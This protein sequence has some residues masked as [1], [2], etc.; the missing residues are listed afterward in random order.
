[1][2]GDEYIEIKLSN[3]TLSIISTNPEISEWVLKLV[4]EIVPSC[5]STLMPPA[6][7]HGREQ[8]T[9]I[10][11][12]PENKQLGICE[13]IAA[14]LPNKGYMPDEFDPSPK[15]RK[16]KFIKIPKKKKIF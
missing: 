14:G 12:L 10:T 1:M 2:F 3:G 5:T 8:E 15:C 4:K 16:Y 6:S 9:S 13:K 11:G 7:R